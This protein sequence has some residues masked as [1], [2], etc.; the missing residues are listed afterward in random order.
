[1][2]LN[3][4]LHTPHRIAKGCQLDLLTKMEAVT[5]VEQN[6]KRSKQE[7]PEQAPLKLAG[8]AAG[9]IGAWFLMASYPAVYPEKALPILTLICQCVQ[10]VCHGLDPTASPYLGCL[11]EAGGNSRNCVR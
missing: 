9:L 2:G 10:T 5:G 6:S 4:E 11:W 8:G 1:M 3:E 7:Q